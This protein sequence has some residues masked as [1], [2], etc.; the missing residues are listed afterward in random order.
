MHLNSDAGGDPSL[1]TFRKLLWSSCFNRR[2]MK[3]K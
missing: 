1:N 2:I 3:S